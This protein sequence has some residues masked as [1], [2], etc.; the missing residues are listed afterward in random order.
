MAGDT[1]RG[2]V[3][4]LLFPLMFPLLF[5]DCSA[6]LAPSRRRSIRWARSRQWTGCPQ[7]RTQIAE[8]IRLQRVDDRAAALQ[9][10][11]EDDAAATLEQRGGEIVLHYSAADRVQSGAVG[12]VL[13]A[14]V[15]DT[16]LRAAGVS[17]PAYAL[18]GEPAPVGRPHHRRINQL[19][20]AI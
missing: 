15:Q 2:D 11:R 17:D 1:G 5:A 20:Q 10:V 13:R 18:I 16:N 6:T 9:Q 4:T 7:G 3:F 14:I 8:A 19:R 12:S